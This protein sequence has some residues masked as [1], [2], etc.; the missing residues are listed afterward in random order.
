MIATVITIDPGKDLLE[1]D[2]TNWHNRKLKGSMN[3]FGVVIEHHGLS[4]TVL[5]DEDGGLVDIANLKKGQKVL[6]NPPKKE[7]KDDE[8]YE[9][10][11]IILLEM[12][13]EEKYERLLAKNTGAYYTTIYFEEDDEL[14]PE[15]EDQLL[16]IA[17]KSPVSFAKYP[18]DYIVDFKKELNIDEL[19]VMLV[20]DNKGLVF[21]TYDI[22]EL[23]DFFND[24]NDKG[25]S[26]NHS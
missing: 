16:S 5:K 10:R 13:F 4:D 22:G 24:L 8:D 11:E 14:P 15:L 6:V 17:P 23:L 1:L 18:I 3:S 25:L 26:F 2:I 20:F 21:K 7:D 19:P 9:V 12:T